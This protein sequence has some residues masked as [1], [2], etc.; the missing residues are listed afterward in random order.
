M[1]SSLPIVNETLTLTKSFELAQRS[2]QLVAGFTQSMMKKPE[3]FALGHFPVY[4]EHAEGALVT[5]IDGNQYID[6]ICGLG[7]NTLGHNHPVVIKAITDNLH[8]GLIHSLPAPVEVRTAETLVNMIPGAEMVRFFKTGADANSAAVRLARYITGKEHIVTVGY[9]G[10]HDQYMFDTP[11]VPETLKHLT[12]RMP[13]FTSADEQPLLDLI[14]SQGSVLAAVLLSVPYNRTLTGEFLHK[15][16]AACTANK[17]LLVMDEVVTGFRLAKGGAQEFFGVLADLV[18][19]SKGIAAGMPL[20]AVAG[21]RE[22]MSKMEALQVST[23]FGGE[24]LSLEVC[25]ATLKEYHHSNYIEHIATLGLRLKEGVNRVSQ[26]LDTPLRVVGY[27][28]IPMFLFSKNLVEHAKIAEKFLAQMAKRGVILRRDVNFICAVHTEEQID[29]TINAV[30][31]SLQ[32]MV[33]ADVFSSTA[34]PA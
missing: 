27:D 32:A 14:N 23:T 3:Q 5:D 1:N 19:L 22:H 15:V 18:S 34:I 17:V 26:A 11:G 8:K 6:F 33:M 21:P 13:L 12:H 16:R 7:A 28:A 25:D 4:I 30:E 31:A 24:M 20:S 10:W 29:F 2:K 9:N